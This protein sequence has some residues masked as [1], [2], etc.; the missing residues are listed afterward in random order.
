MSLVVT[1]QRKRV[2]ALVTPLPPLQA[3]LSTAEERRCKL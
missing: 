2:V 3:A 1:G